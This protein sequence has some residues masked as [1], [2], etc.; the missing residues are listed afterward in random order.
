MSDTDHSLPLSTTGRDYDR[1]TSV[2]KYLLVT[3]VE[4]YIAVKFEANIMCI[5][6]KNSHVSVNAK[7][8]AAK[9][10]DDYCAVQTTVLLVA[11]PVFSILNLRRGIGNFVSSEFK[12][13]DQTVLLTTSIDN[14]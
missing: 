2:S 4:S 5:S 13:V 8:S 12:D 1:S 10:K 14:N 9:K 11:V 3:A 6:F 7:T